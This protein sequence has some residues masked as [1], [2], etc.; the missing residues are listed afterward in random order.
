MTASARRS[1]RSG[2]TTDP[3][4]ALAIARIGQRDADL[5]PPSPHGDTEELRCLV[6]YRREPL[7]DRVRQI[8]RLQADLRQ[9]RL[10]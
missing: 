10:G 1:Q 9:L 7:A 8:N 6:R 2:S 3:G 5:P 4:D